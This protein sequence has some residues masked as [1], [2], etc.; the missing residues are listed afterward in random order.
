M[1]AVGHL[2]AEQHLGLQQD[3][4]LLLQFKN[5][6]NKKSAKKLC[7]KYS[8]ETGTNLRSRSFQNG[9]LHYINHMLVFSFI[10]K[11]TFICN[12]AVSMVCVKLAPLQC[13]IKSMPI[14]KLATQQCLVKIMAAYSQYIVGYM[15]QVFLAITVKGLKF[16]TDELGCPGVGRTQPGC[17][18]LGI[19]SLAAFGILSLAPSPSAYGIPSVAAQEGLLGLAQLGSQQKDTSLAAQKRCFQLGCP[20]PE[21]SFP[22]S[23]TQTFFVDGVSQQDLMASLPDT[24]S[25]TVEQNLSHSEFSHHVNLLNLSLILLCSWLAP[26]NCQSQLNI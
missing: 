17:L 22:S 16:V 13:L 7:I 21:A 11:I 2:L 12:F 24:C 15:D 18:G 6:Y 14:N 4:V 26:C 9:E 3:V 20:H 10:F 25:F 8:R 5:N 23:G 19:L 1:A